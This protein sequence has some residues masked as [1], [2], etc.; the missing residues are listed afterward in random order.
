[1]NL[2]LNEYY[3]YSSCLSDTNNMNES[4][5][6][7]YEFSLKK[8]CRCVELPI[9]AEKDEIVVKHLKSKK[10]VLLVDVLKTIKNIAFNFNHYPIIFSV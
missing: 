5:L 4:I 9:Y 10:S 6:Q 3:V 8:G 1:M 2:P 7:T